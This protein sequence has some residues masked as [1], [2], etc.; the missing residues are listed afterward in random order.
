MLGGAVIIDTRVHPAQIATNSLDGPAIVY[1]CV[2]GDVDMTC[3]RALGKAAAQL[4]SAAPDTVYIDLGTVTF[5]GSTLLNFLARIVA[6]LPDPSTLVLCRPTPYTR[7]LIHLTFPD[8]VA[9]LREDLPRDW[10]ETGW[11]S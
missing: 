3:E 9:T 4:Q 7:D 8:L 11:T 2:A 5:G 10:P 6:N 1:L